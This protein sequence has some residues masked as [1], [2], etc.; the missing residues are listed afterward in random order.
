MITI[1]ILIFII[2]LVIIYILSK[3][4]KNPYTKDDEDIAQKALQE[5]N[6][7]L[8]I[9]KEIPHVKDEEL[10]KLLKDVYLVKH[11]NMIEKLSYFPE[12]NTKYW[13]K[14][15]YSFPYT[16]KN[17][18]AWPPGMYS[19][20]Y[21][22]SP[23][24]YSGSGWQYYLRPGISYKYWPRNRWIR[25]TKNGKNSYYYVTNRD[26]YTHNAAN[27]KDLPIYKY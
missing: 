13:P 18:G 1:Y 10:Y 8:K 19:R 5:L 9:G 6:K 17:G 26:D 22:W 11:P 27:Y 14:Y 16:Y 4:N 20:L 3:N 12:A 25:N 15:Y 21:F 24:F 7:S 2:I 23:G